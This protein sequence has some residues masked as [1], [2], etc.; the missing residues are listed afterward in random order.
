MNI[1][2]GTILARA[3][4]EQWTQQAATAKLRENPK[5]AREI[6]VSSLPSEIL[7]SEAASISLRDRAENYREKMAGLGE[8]LMPHLQSLSPGALLDESDKID[9]MDRVARR[10]FGLDKEIGDR[11][12]INMNLLAMGLE[13]FASKPVEQ[14]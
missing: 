9:R 7:P 12:L 4:K 6:M 10:A 13:V 11:P 5:L 2:A 8:R 14:V 3:K 1:P